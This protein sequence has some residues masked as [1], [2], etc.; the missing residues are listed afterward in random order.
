MP[1]GRPSPI[2]ELPQELVEIIT[3]YFIYD[4]RS[5][6]ACSL[7]CYSWYIAVVPHLHHTLTTKD[8]PIWPADRNHPW[9]RPLKKSYELGLLP[10]VKRFR[11]R[12]TNVAYP[13]F[14]PAWLSERTLRYFSALTNL[15]DLGIDYLNVSSFMP[16]IRQCFGHFSPTLR[17]IA[18]KQPAGSCRQIVYF[19]GLFPNLQDI[20]LN[21]SF[22]TDEPDGAADPTLIPL[23]V[24]PLC[25]RL[26]LTCFTRE[27]LV[28]DMIVFFG[29]LRFRH[30]DLF[31]VRCVRL[32]LDACTETLETLKLYPSDPYREEFLKRRWGR[33]QVNDP[34]SIADDQAL[35]QHFNLSRIK[36]LRTLETTAES[37]NAADETASD[38][39]KTVLSSVTPSAPL[40]VVVVYRDIDLSNMPHCSR[41]DSALVRLRHS[42]RDP[43]AR[44]AHFRHQF[45]VFREMRSVRDFRLV[46]CVDVFDCMVEGSVEMLERAAIVEGVMGESERLLRKP[47]IISER[48]TLRTF[49]LDENA[50]WS[51]EGVS[52]SAL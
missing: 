27:N 11:I 48:R 8:D 52:A 30:M 31:R 37:I 7:T 20:K 22:P 21:Y 16:T 38:F 39:L 23:S 24:P 26:T 43:R 25:G 47:L 49:Y 1:T 32:L 4:T 45:R 44:V 2:T 13:M 9:P 12:M 46:L 18:L 29:G 14:A 10:L 3:S 5:L 51:G 42:W 6:L 19:I 50:G 35:L 17:F 36:S 40:N 41:C 33:T 15:Q 34:Y 28:K